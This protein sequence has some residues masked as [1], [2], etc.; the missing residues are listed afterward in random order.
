[1]PL[2]NKKKK[3]QRK[4]SPIFQYFCSGK[5]HTQ[6]QRHTHTHIYIINMKSIE[7]S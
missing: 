2:R 4:S 7:E 6:T 1:M 5:A 3:K